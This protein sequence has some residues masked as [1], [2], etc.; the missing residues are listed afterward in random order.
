MDYKKKVLKNG[1]R[2]VVVPVKGAPSVTVMSL[3]EAGSKYENKQNNGISHFLEHMCFKGT[4]KRPKAGDIAREFDAMGAQNNA[5]TSQEYTGYWG[6]A[7]KKHTDHILEI[8]A[9]MYLN[10][11]FPEKDLE[12]EKGVIVEEINM[13]KD[14]PKI[15]VQEVFDELLYG[16]QPAGWSIAGTKENV[17]S[18]NRNDFV[19]YRKQ[20]YVASA[21]EIIIAGDVEPN[22]IFKKVEKAFI[23]ISTSKK[24]EKKK[25]IERQNNP[26]VKLMFK[27]TDQ[28]H[29]ILG[30]RTFDTYD[31]RNRTLRL[32][33]TVLGNGMSSRLFQKMRDE[34]GICYYVRSHAD[35]MTDHGYLA[36]S[37]GL[38]SNRV[39]EGIKGILE[40]LKK[41]RDK[42]ISEPE[43]RKAKDLAIGR[44]YLGLES[45]DSL[46]DFYGFQEIFKKKIKTP[47][48]IEKEIEKVSATDIQKLAKEIITNKKLN[49]AIVG[50][51]KDEERFKKILKV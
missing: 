18:F 35:S 29:I 36:V 4:E 10:P 41:I 31:S 42:K 8:I 1:L 26:K 49:L 9:D 24:I 17:R 44:M 25:V 16:N 6:K 32:L 11:T 33:S 50:R 47:K 12:T 51:Y 13:Y 46:A 40:E 30:F 38:D 3:I 28:T 45:S 15:I 14:L 43:L 21:T 27:E 37:A 20:H 19:N 5:F 34:L 23:G 22:N 7:H 48:E 39:E 2:I